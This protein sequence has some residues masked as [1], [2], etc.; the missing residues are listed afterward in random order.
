M[1]IDHKQL[2]DLLIETSG[3]DQEK[4]EKQIAELID[5]INQAVADGE[6]YEIEGFGIF[7][8]LGDRILFIPSKEL[9]TEINFKYVGMEPIELDEDQVSPAPELE[10][11][12]FESLQGESSANSRDPF[13]GLVEDFDE[14][15][16]PEGTEDS[17]VFGVESEKDLGTESDAEAIE[18]EQVPGP[19]SWGIEA[20]KEGSESANK[21][22]SS[23]MGEEYLEQENADQESAEE[24]SVEEDSF[25][26]IFG[27]E[28]QEVEADESHTQEEASV[29]GLDAELASLMGDDTTV[30][31]SE[32]LEA[33]LYEEDIMDVFSELESED[34][35]A[36]ELAEPEPS[37]EER[38]EETLDEIIDEISTEELEEVLSESEST[39]SVEDVIEEEETEETAQEEITDVEEELEDEFDDFDDPFLDLEEDEEEELPPANVS[40]SE[41]IIPVIKN[42]TSGVISKKEEPGEKEEAK[43]KVKPPKAPKKEAKPAPVWLWIILFLVIFVGGTAG[44][45]YYGIVNIP[46]ITPGYEVAS[47][48]SEPVTQPPQ[49]QTPPAEAQPQQQEET[50][51]QAEQQSPVQ[52]Q[53][54]P[55]PVQQPISTPQN[56]PEGQEL[57]G[58]TGVVSEAA[59]DG[60]TIVL[61]SLSIEQNAYAKQ[62]ELSNAGYRAFV[63]PVPSTQYGTLWRVSIG[64]FASLRDAAIGAE[65]MPSEYQESYFIKRIT[66]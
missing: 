46:G 66:N 48:T 17:I 11:D 47:N 53:A 62:Q 45:G 55:P 59:N 3:Q 32:E 18:E 27:E 21:L 29:G 58:L 52:E 38:E 34:E 33:G 39:E 57:Y 50:T 63:T 51:T 24:E 54:A 1:H 2:L 64:Q 5:E 26:D 13:A 31:S 16:K 6:A 41:E 8:G 20:H 42:I 14:E 22:I 9:E 19:D 10:E 37:L 36:S 15:E 49:Q 7:S 28:E 65:E 35:E 43:P 40:H 4:I 61:F 44:L 23:L 12:P 60:Y 56:V 30:T 25:E